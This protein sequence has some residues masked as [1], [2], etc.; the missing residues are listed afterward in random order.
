MRGTHATTTLVI[1]TVL[2]ALL[3]TGC[4]AFGGDDSVP[5]PTRRTAV[6]GS[7]QVPAPGPTSGTQAVTA[8]TVM[9]AG[10]V[11]AETDVVSASGD[12]RIHVRVVADGHGTFEAELSG[13]RTTKPQPMSLEFRRGDVDG[14][15]P[16]GFRA[17]VVLWDPA[18]GAPTSVGL[19]DAG[20]TPD[21]LHSVV[22]VPAPSDGDDSD[23]PW[24]GSVLAAA[25][26][27]WDLPDPYPD[28]HVTVGSPR[29]GA[30]G[31]VH[32]EDGTPTSYQV[33]NGDEQ[34][35]IADRF[36]LTVAELQWLNPSLQTGDPDALLAATDLNLVPSGR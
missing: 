4:S 6:D 22:L 14:D 32:D 20:P 15:D 16:S 9:P 19:G 17:G 23:R 33:A 21:F 7:G 18:T 25:P 2:T 11:A 13:Y 36:G 26:L 24:V 28:L 8:A 35:V 1:G 31:W 10:T 27:H 12:T 3:L 29:Q 5:E 30:Y 34:S